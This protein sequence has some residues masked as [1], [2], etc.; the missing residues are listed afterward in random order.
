MNIDYM[1]EMSHY[2]GSIRPYYKGVDKAEAYPNTEKYI[3]MEMPGGQYSN[4]Q[5]QS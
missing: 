1:E 2:F 4:L 5:Q 3:N